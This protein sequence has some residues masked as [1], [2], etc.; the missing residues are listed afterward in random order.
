MIVAVR[1]EMDSRPIV[2]SL[3]RALKDFGSM[4]LVSDNK[5]VQRLIDSPEDGAC[6]NIRIVYDAD[7]AFDSVAEE[8]GIVADEYDFLILDNVGAM[9]Y[10]VL[11]V[12]VGEIITDSFQ[13]DIDELKKDTNT[14][15]IQFGKAG[16]NQASNNKKSSRSSKPKPEKKRPDRGKRRGNVEEEE[17]DAIT[18][19]EED[20]DPA[21]KFR[22]DVSIDEEYN[23]SER[24]Y[25]CDFPSWQDI[26]DLEAKHLFFKLNQKVADAI[27]DI[28]KQQ[29]GIDKRMFS[30]AV[31][32]ADRE[33]RGHIRSTEADLESNP[34]RSRRKRE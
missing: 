21:E 22:M 15:F 3:L 32:V 34:K 7:G 23:V 29:L 26:E 1:S 13:F 14:R 17:V 10:D 19:L 33:V 6:R 16:K 25:G 9:D 18:N 28:F 2:Y 30:K 31:T 4:C 24:F 27:Y 20:D 5:F 12:P 11:I 8:Y